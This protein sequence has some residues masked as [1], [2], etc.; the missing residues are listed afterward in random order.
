MY[1]KGEVAK[2][3]DSETPFC[4]VES[5]YGIGEWLSPHRVKTLDD[6]MWRY[7]K[8]GDWYLCVNKP[9]QVTSHF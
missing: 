2:T 8:E 9:L 5:V 3:R 6:V 1:E 4:F 7:H